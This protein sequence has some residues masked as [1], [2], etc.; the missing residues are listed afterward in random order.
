ME[1]K[2]YKKLKSNIY[3]IKFKSGEAVKL[4]DEVILNY[5]LLITKNI[6]NKEYEEIIKYNKSLDAYYL[7]LKYL[8]SKQ[9]CEKEIRDY[10]KKKDFSHD[11][12]DKTIDKLNKYNYLD[13]DLYVKSYINDKYNFGISGPLKIKRELLNLGFTDEEIDKYLNKD[14]NEKIDKIIQKKIKNNNKLNEYNL[15]I[16]ITNY[17]TN[18]GYP[19]EMFAEYL[20]DIKVDNK[21]IIK[22]DIE[23]L[24]KK[25]QKKYQGKEL[26]YFIKRK[27]YQKGYREEEIGDVLIENIL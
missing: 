12:I 15:K 13:R 11:T 10:L 5:N 20:N 3:E 22:K 23:K 26:Y 21:V 2:E 1:I 7:S 16:N 18:L 8:N 19:K 14:F 6:S 27:L 9:R 25:Y 4:Y 17:L 24:I